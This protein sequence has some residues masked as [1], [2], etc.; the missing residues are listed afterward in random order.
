VI[1]AKALADYRLQVRFDDG[2]AGL[3]D[4]R[5]LVLGPRA[6]VFAMLA[7]P[8]LFS[9]V[10]VHHGAVNWPGELD[11]APDAMHDALKRD[12]SWTLN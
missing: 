4:C 2:T 1:E 6:G 12:S 9:Q 8:S 11:L 3:V 7:D 5:E 10:H